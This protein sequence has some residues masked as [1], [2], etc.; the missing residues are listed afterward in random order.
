MEKNNVFY[1]LQKF[2]APT[3]RSSS[4][5]VTYIGSNSN[6]AFGIVHSGTATTALS[7]ANSPYYL[8]SDSTVATSEAAVTSSATSV[9]GG[10][11]YFNISGN[12]AASFSSEVAL[13]GIGTIGATS[14]TDTAYFYLGSAGAD[15]FGEASIV[16]SGV[17]LKPDEGMSNTKIN[18]ATLNFSLATTD[19]YVSF[20]GGKTFSAGASNP[21]LTAGTGS[22]TQVA[23]A[24]IDQYQTWVMADSSVSLT[25][26]ETSY[27]ASDTATVTAGDTNGTYLNFAVGNDS[28]KSAINITDN[29]ASTVKFG[30]NSTVVS[31]T[32]GIVD[33]AT[34]LSS[35]AIKLHMAGSKEGTVTA[36]AAGVLSFASSSHSDTATVTAAGITA[37]ENLYNASWSNLAS[38]LV[39]V[40][41]EQWAFSDKSNVTLAGADTDGHVAYVSGL[42]SS[43]NATVTM[44]SDG[45]FKIGAADSTIPSWN[46]SNTSITNA[47]DVAVFDGTGVA[48]T[49]KAGSTGNVVAKGNSS[50][51]PTLKASAFNGD[52]LV[53]AEGGAAVTVSGTAIAAASSIAAG[54]DW[55]VYGK[56]RDVTLGNTRVSLTNSVNSDSLA[57]AIQSKSADATNALGSIASLS[58]NAA[59][60][61]GSWASGTNDSL[62]NVTVMG[63]EW[64]FDKMQTSTVTFDSLGAATIAA[65]TNAADGSALSVTGSDGANVTAVTLNSS[66]NSIAAYLNGQLGYFT[67]DTNGAVG[68]ELETGSAT[69]GIKGIKDFGKGAYATI[70]GDNDFTVAVT[71][72]NTY[73]FTNGATSD[74]DNRFYMTSDTKVGLVV[75]NLDE[76]AN[77][78]V[79]GGN[80]T[81]VANGAA[82][83][84]T[85]NVN[86]DTAETKTLTL[87]GTTVSISANAIGGATV[88]A[89]DTDG[90]ATISGVY[91]N[92]TI[93][94]DSDQAF[95]V[96]FT[97]ATSGSSVR[98]FNVNDISLTFDSSTTVPGIFTMNVDQTSGGNYVTIK[99]G[100]LGSSSLPAI[101]ASQGVYQVGSGAAV[102]INDSLGGYLYWSGTALTGEDMSVYDKRVAREEAAANASTLATS[103]STVGG[104]AGFRNLSNLPQSVT[105]GTVAG[106]EDGSTLAT[107]E[108]VDGGIN[109]YGNTSLSAATSVTL[110]SDVDGGVNISSNEGA[111]VKNAIIDFTGGDADLAII[112]VNGTVSANHT[113]LASNAQSTVMFGANASGGSNMAKAGTGGAYLYNEGKKASLIGNSGNDTIWAQSGDFVEGGAEADYFYDSGNYTIRD[114]SVSDGDVLVVTQVSTSTGVKRNQISANQNV[115]QIGT[116]GAITLGTDYDDDEQSQRQVIINSDVG[117]SVNNQYIAW[118]SPYGTDNI[119]VSEFV[120]GKKGALVLADEND[121]AADS[122]TGSANGDTIYAGANDTIN[123]G[124]GADL[125]VLSTVSAGNDEGIKVSLSAGANTV[126]GWSYGFQNSEAGNSQLLA[127][128]TD[129]SD[130]KF[131]MKNGYLT[132]S[133]TSNRASVTFADQV[134]SGENYDI[135]YGD[136][137]IRFIQSG[138]NSTIS[139]DDNVADFYTAEK[140]A[141]LTFAS[142]VESSLNINLSDSSQF[143]SI[144]AVNVETEAVATV[145]GGSAKETVQVSGSLD[146]NAV[147]TVSLGG[148]NDVIISTGDDTDTAGNLLVFGSG[149]GKDT[150]QNF[151][152]YQGA[153]ADPYGEAADTLYLTQYASLKASNRSI[154]ISTTSSDK[155]VIARDSTDSTVS[156]DIMKLQIGNA[157]ATMKVGRYT[158][159]GTSHANSFTYDSS[160]NLYYGNADASKDSLTVS[161][162]ENT[163]IW[164][165]GEP[166]GKNYIGVNAIDA[167][168]ATDANFTLIGSSGNNTLVGAGSGSYTTL[169]G[170]DSGNNLINGGAGEDVLYYGGRSNDTVSNF[171]SDDVIWL[172]SLNITNTD[173]YTTSQIKF[174]FSEGGSL[175]VNSNNSGVKF[176]LTDNTE[177][178]LNQTTGEWTQV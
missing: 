112:G 31:G 126:E 102:T 12:V 66:N 13:S 41:K 59:I 11:S 106:Y 158:T 58:G 94:T 148:G 123:A 27:K 22:S 177:W 46:I 174:N 38:T 67:N 4:S 36:G 16:G 98:S 76:N 34:A 32:A 48:V 104:Y 54:T 164:L 70:T 167:S 97:N 65:G 115:I 135:L 61:L 166:S 55:L 43:A 95:A 169:W 14:N 91:A 21:T 86:A 175:V 137:K 78:N 52:S 35:S 142:G 42:G 103:Y 84:Q 162:D 72:G 101:T 125:I 119:D 29:G 51:A 121:N 150:I 178:S 113:V 120:A 30:L 33:S 108:S 87:N 2:A 161:T 73:S 17:S 149:D 8:M 75:T 5:G 109:I 74:V 81:F 100:D 130:L 40:G 156:D 132:L 107:N 90:I 139:S 111:S 89:N 155:V 47:S 171:T 146:N 88:S 18:G 69:T 64:S 134:S 165:S 3:L 19:K 154:E 128:T 24:S 45:I 176:R 129:Y 110:E 160:V 23:L 131:K 153:D 151:S 1:D 144:S 77:Y 152:Y 44:Q 10:G 170:A 96:V 172:G 49:L 159:G 145:I 28:T 141:T 122:V 60:T 79:T 85:T 157:T 147:K 136:T 63:T 56:G 68:F 143:V 62:D 93:K 50:D 71:G 92:S 124:A 168:G 53:L 173:Y 80:V 140:N 114:Y 9:V 99:G 117:S 163:E 26:A 118:A 133:D 57:A 82:A 39:S 25:F 7:T 37:V 6:A 116:G 15:Y 83:T 127:T 20:S 138:R 105:S